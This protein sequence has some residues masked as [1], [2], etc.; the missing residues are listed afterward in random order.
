MRASLLRLAESA[1]KKPLN[2]RDASATLLPPVPYA[3]PALRGYDFASTLLLFSL[4]RRL[5]RS[6]RNL[7]PEMR[8]LGDDYVKAGKNNPTMSRELPSDSSRLAPQNSNDTRTSQ[9]PRTLSASSPNGRCTWIR[10]RR[11]RMATRSRGKG[12]TQ[13]SL[14]R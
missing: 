5:L 6:H 14:R 13:L 10:C 3:P 11:E 4:Y 9:I 7:P 1:T 8:S 2:L 12:W